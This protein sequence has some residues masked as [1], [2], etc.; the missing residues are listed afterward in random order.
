MTT[1]NPH[2]GEE[3]SVGLLWLSKTLK[4][5]K[6]GSTLVEAIK[7]AGTLYW[8]VLERLNFGGRQAEYEFNRV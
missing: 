3:D 6:A 5:T 1:R 4:D 8:G 2:L 7:R